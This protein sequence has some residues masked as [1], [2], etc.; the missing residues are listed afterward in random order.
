M[1]IATTDA[2]G[3]YSLLLVNV[4]AIFNLLPQLS[5]P[6]ETAT[7]LFLHFTNYPVPGMA[8]LATGA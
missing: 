2:P 4:L 6:A 3:L 7:V 5:G 1:Q 8:G